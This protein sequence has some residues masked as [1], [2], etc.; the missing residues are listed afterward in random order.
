MSLA[1]AL[2]MYMPDDFIQ[3]NIRKKRVKEIWYDPDFASYN[4]K[5]TKN[6]LKGECKNCK[7]GKQC[8]G[9]CLTV[10]QTITGQNHNDPYCLFLIEQEIMK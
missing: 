2:I 9:G 5:F 1:F 8:R 7:H 3:G 10:S 6:D 4:R